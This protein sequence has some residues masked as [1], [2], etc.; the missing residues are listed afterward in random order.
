MTPEETAKIKLLTNPTD[1]FNYV[2]DHM[3]K[4][5]KQSLFEGGDTCAYRGDGGTMCAVGCLMTDDEYDPSWENK[6]ITVL[7]EQNMLNPDL[8][9]RIEPNLQMLSDLQLLHDNYL[10][11]EDGELT[12]DTKIRINNLREKWDIE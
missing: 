3:Q 5:G 6:G 8:K 7:V 4:Q 9:K 10:S 1:V 2:V 11:Y 12:E